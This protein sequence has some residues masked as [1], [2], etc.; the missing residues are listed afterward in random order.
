VAH[1]IV[2]QREGPDLLGAVHRRL[3]D[4]GGQV[5]LE[6]GDVAGLV[7]D[8]TVEDHVDDRPVLRR[9]GEV[10]VEVGQVGGIHA[11]AERRSLLRGSGAD[12]GTTERG[13]DQHRRR[14]DR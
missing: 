1:R 14:E 5:R 6:F 4:G 9:R 12:K 3:G 7:A 8:E 13:Q 10:G 11:E 2:A